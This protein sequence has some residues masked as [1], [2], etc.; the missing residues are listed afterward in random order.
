MKQAIVIPKDLF[1]EVGRALVKKCRKSDTPLLAVSAGATHAHL[2]VELRDDYTRA[3]EYTR[4]L[5]IAGSHAIR[6]RMPGNVW[7]RGGRPIAV[8]DL[9]HQRRVYRYILEHAEHGD[10]VW[11]FRQGEILT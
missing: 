4:R 9:A 2:L 3:E 10:W 8:R 1:G 6:H 11:D 5:K 7:A